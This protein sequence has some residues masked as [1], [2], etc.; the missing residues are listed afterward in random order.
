M[1]K[2]PLFPFLAFNFFL[3]SLIFF[4]SNETKQ[5]KKGNSGFSWKTDFLRFYFFFYFCINC[6]IN[7]I[8]RYK[9]MFVCHCRRRFCRHTHFLFVFCFYFWFLLLLLSFCIGKM[10]IMD[11]VFLIRSKENCTCYLD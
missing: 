11:Y 9:S 5:I 8:L 7:S 10:C 6:G 2:S 4:F 1:S 3:F